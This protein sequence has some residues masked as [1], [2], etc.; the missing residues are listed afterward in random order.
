MQPSITLLSY[1]KIQKSQEL[2]SALLTHQES[3][4]IKEKSVG[5]FSKWNCILAAGAEP[6][7]LKGYSMSTHREVPL[8]HSFFPCISLSRKPNASRLPAGCLKSTYR[9]HIPIQELRHAHYRFR[10]R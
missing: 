9:G 6:V 8:D 5:Y 4:C 3:C 7:N 2:F 10:D 1:N